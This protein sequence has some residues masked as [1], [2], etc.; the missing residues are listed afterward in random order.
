MSEIIKHINASYRRVLVPILK[1]NGFEIFSGKKAWKYLDDRIY[2]FVVSGVG[3]DFSNVTGFSSCSLTASLNIYYPD[4]S[5]VPKCKKI[6]KDGHLL[7]A[8]TQCYYRFGFEKN[9]KQ[10]G[11]DRRD[12]WW[13]A[14][15]GGN[16]EEVLSDIGKTLMEYGLPLVERPHYSYGVVASKHGS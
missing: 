10:D 4:L 8:E 12:V 9:I 11:Y 15:D 7:P 2:L 3:A 6:H 5:G 16:V 13:V 1:E 14:K